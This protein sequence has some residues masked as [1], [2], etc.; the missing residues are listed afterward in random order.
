MTKLRLRGN[1]KY[2]NTTIPHLRYSYK[3][4]KEKKAMKTEDPHNLQR[5]VSAQEDNYDTAIQELRRGRK[6]S[7][8]IWYVFPQVAGLGYSSMAQ[9]YAIG[10]RNEALEY[11]H[12][13]ILNQRLLDCCEAL[14]AH[15]DSAIID[16]MGSPDDMKLRSSMTLFASV[17]SQ[18]APFQS[19]L[20]TFYGGQN[21]NKTLEFLTPTSQTEWRNRTSRSRR[22]RGIHLIK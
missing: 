21:D 1:F 7:H 15:R 2:I 4:G 17:S 12:H 5:F 8:W 13:P 18:P 3:F 9:Y 22:R 19:V 11:L 14:L 20:D 6:K 10:S 16:I